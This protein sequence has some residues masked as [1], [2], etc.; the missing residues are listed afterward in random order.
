[1]KKRKMIFERSVN[2]E[3]R[4]GTVEFALILVLVAV[5]VIATLSLMGP[6]IAD[7]F[8]RAL[9]GLRMGETEEQ[10]AILAIKNDFLGRI[11]QFFDDINGTDSWRIVQRSIGENA[12][13]EETIQR[14]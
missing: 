6:T 10:N 13:P 11:N 12:R 4:Q 5:V 9:S 8:N 14:Q 1:M 7:G 2:M 3:A